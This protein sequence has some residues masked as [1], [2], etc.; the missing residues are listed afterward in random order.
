MLNF[1]QAQTDL[2]NNTLD[3]STEWSAGGTKNKIAV[4]KAYEMIYDLYKNYQKI[5]RRMVLPKTSVSFT[6]KV[7]NLPAD[8]DTVDIVSLFDFTTDSDLDGIS[9][10]RYFAFEIRGAQASRKMYIETNE[11]V[12]YISYI[13]LRTD[14]TENTDA[15]LLPAEIHPCITDFAKYFYRQMIL[16]EV[17]A[18]NALSLA[19][20]I[21]DAKLSSL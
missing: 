5:K 19:Q 20:Q 15:F 13:P 3:T 21:I 9:D 10:G 14:L 8:F 11:S 18:A 1:L 2:A 16:D 12:L 17:G 7:G 6:N 4:N